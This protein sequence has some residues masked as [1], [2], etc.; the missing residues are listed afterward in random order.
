MKQFIAMLTVLL[1]LA[2]LAT[3]ARAGDAEDVTAAVLAVDAAY[4]SGNAEIVAQYLHPDHTR[5]PSPGVLGAGLL[6]EGFDKETLAAR[7][8]AGLDLDITTRHLAVDVYGN[9]AIATG[10]NEETITQPS[11]VVQ[12]EVARFTEVWIK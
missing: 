4:N 10:Y 11:G 8:K 1:A 7:F 3:P 9:T 12:R 6:A 2:P 5:F